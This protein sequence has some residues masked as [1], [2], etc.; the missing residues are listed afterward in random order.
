[1]ISSQQQTCVCRQVRLLAQLLGKEKNR[2]SEQQHEVNIIVNGR[3][4]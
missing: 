2:M 3:P 4:K 1:M